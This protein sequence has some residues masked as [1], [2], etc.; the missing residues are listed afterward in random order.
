MINYL[1]TKT[2]L[3]FFA[4]SFWRDEAFT[5]FL[6]KENVFKITSLTAKDFN[7]PLYYL[8]IHFWMKIFGTSEITLRLFSLIFFW[9]T[10][11]VGFLF[12][13]NIFNLSLKKSFLYL[14]FFLFNPLL[15]YYAFEARMYTFFAFLS[16]LSFYFFYQRKKLPFIIFTLAGLYT[17]Y[18]M[19]FVIVGQLLFIFLER[20]KIWQKQIKTIVISLVGF[21]PWVFFLFF[22]QVIFK[23]SFWLTKPKFLGVLHLL[24]V[25]YTGHEDVNQ[26]LPEIQ[27]VEKIIFFLNL[28]LFFI[29]FIGILKIVNFKKKTDQN[30]FLF[31]S[32][33]GILIPLSVGL[34]SFLKPIYLPRYLIFAT[35]GFLILLIFILNKLTK[36]STIFFFLAIMLLTFF[37]N[38][39]QIKYRRK[40]DLRKTIE[41]IKSISGK[42]DLLY[43]TDE[44]DY[45]VAKYY[46]D[47]KRVY[48]FQKNYQEI[49][50]YVGKVLIPPEQITFKLPIYPQKAF[51]LKNDG[52]YSIQA[53]Y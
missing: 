18:F 10:I 4:Q 48:I 24:A 27:T 7:P 52:S 44:L 37:Y 49:P 16:S 19:F 13:R 34:I 46:F 42:T 11:Y 43:V 45:F 8:I 12:L 29:V 9:A 41:E 32:I 30:L 15:I 35:V 14:L 25:I 47:E 17:H 40:A 3:L 53:M 22:N 51:V 1:F 33:W 26:Y 2:P 23:E 31:L 20:A 36:K 5:Y 50:Q 38:R 6:A 28:V 39:Y 21:L